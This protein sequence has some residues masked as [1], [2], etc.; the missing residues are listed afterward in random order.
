MSMGSWGHFIFKVSSKTIMAPQDIARSAGSNWAMHN[1]IGGKP[2]AQYQGPALRSVTCKIQLRADFGVKPRQQL[3]QLANM[4][5]LRYAWPLI[6]GGKQ[7]AKNPFRL[8]GVSETWNTVYNG[9]EL[10]S[11]EVALTFEEYV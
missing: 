10:F 4:A 3:D 5:E 1:T 9:G 2:K 11:A 6:I 7:L 8:T